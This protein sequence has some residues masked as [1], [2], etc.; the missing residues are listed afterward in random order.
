MEIPVLRGREFDSQDGANS[1]AEAIVNMTLARALWIM[2][3]RPA[4]VTR[5][6]G[7]LS[8]ETIQM[9]GLWMIGVYRVFIWIMFLLVIWLTIWSAKLKRIS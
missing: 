1:P 2:N 3:G 9:T 8:W 7:G 5:M 4:W 6:W